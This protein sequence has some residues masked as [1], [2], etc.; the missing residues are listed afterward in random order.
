MKQQQNLFYNQ[1]IG[2][3]ELKTVLQSAFTNFGLNTAAFLSNQLKTVGF[4]YATKAG[5]SISI[6]DLKVPPLKKLLVSKTNKQITQTEIKAKRGEITDVERFQ[7]VVNTWS[8]TSEYLKD[9]VVSYF[10]E[11][12]P[13]NSVYMMAFSGAR[14][15]LSQVRQLVGMRGLMS[16]SKGQII[17]LPIKTNFREG[18][19][20]TDYII[21]SYGA[22][23]GLVDTALKTADS[24]YLT[25]R[26]IDVA[27][28][29]ITREYD[30]GTQTG[31]TITTGL[32]QK[33]LP[34]SFLE[35]FIG[36]VLVHEIINPFTNEIIANQY[37]ILDSELLDKIVKA[38][39]KKIIIRSPLS[40]ELNHS[41]CQLCYGWNL[42]SGNIVDLGEAIGII[43]AQSIGEP[44][45]QLTMR[46]F[47]TGGV[48]T[49]EASRQFRSEYSG[50]ILLPENCIYQTLRTEYGQLV[51]IPDKD[52]TVTL[53]TYSNKV[54]KLDILAK[55]KIFVQ[56]NEY[57]KKDD[58]LFEFP[59]L[60][61]KSGGEKI[62]KPVFAKN[63]GE[64]FLKAT[65]KNQNNFTNSN[66]I[67][68]WVL[69]A[70]IYK[71]PL[72]AK[73]KFKSLCWIDSNTTLA[74][75]ILTNTQAGRLETSQIQNQEIETM[76]VVHNSYAFEQ[77][78]IYCEAI[79]SQF[80]GFSTY[81]NQYS[82]L[83]I[84][85][86]F[87]LNFNQK[88]RTS[89][90]TIRNQ[91]L[92]TQTGGIF[93]C[94][95]SLENSTT[96]SELLE[97]RVI[98]TGTTLF[99]IPESNHS[100]R[101]KLSDLNLSE[102]GYLNAFINNKD[103]NEVI[104]VSGFVETQNKKTTKKELIIKPACFIVLTSKETAAYYNQQIFYPGEIIE[105]EFTV[106]RLC[107]GE[108]KTIKGGFLLL[109]R[110]ITRYEIFKKEN[111]SFNQFF[112]SSFPTSD[113]EVK[114]SNIINS[115]FKRVKTSVPIQIEEN[116]II[117]KPANSIKPDI[118]L[119]KSKSNTFKL[120]INL[121]ET[122]KVNSLIPK[123]LK[124]ED[125]FLSTLTEMGQFIEPYSIV[126]TCEILTTKKNYIY[127]IKEQFFDKQKR[128]LLVTEEDYISFF[129]ENNKFPLSK[130]LFIYNKDIIGNNLTVQES[131]LIREINGSKILMQKGKPY[132]FSAGT[133]LKKNNTF[134]INKNDILGSLIYER[135]RTGDIVQGLPRVEEILEARNPK[136]E[137]TL[138]EQSG[139]IKKIEN[140][141]SRI[142][143][144]VKGVG[145]KNTAQ[146]ELD[147]YSILNRERLLINKFEFVNVGQCLND[148]QI[149][150]HGLLKICFN[151]YSTLQ[152][153]SDYR[154]AQK[155]FKR[156][157][158]L[159]LNS[160]QGVYYSQGV[161]ISDKHIEI[162]IKQM[163]K[164]VQISYA[165]GLDLLPEEII[166]LKQIYF[167]NK[168]IHSEDKAKFLPIL[169]GIT[170]ASLKTESFIA[171]ASFQ[172]TT[173]IL[174][175]AAIQGKVDWLRGL[176]ENVIVG[177]LIPAGTGFGAYIDI[178]YLK[179][180]IP[181]L[182]TDYRP[183]KPNTK[184]VSLRQKLDLKKK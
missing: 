177:R 80:N 143:I 27:Q 92:K 16:D 152:L 71:V 157:Q 166:D 140:E 42:A 22:R 19:T 120:S 68:A 73:L 50:Q 113:I 65:D 158:F 21:S 124:K 165:G 106:K 11:T 181:T 91:Q 109:F 24:G 9:R 111:E 43:A 137:A 86:S 51:L 148:A 57:I 167:M 66:N 184:Y 30:C 121:S 62:I 10:K 115:T 107:Y 183:R 77:L 136:T 176:K 163:T 8:G 75:T 7:K 150:P 45:T 168:C 1:I 2:K 127:K 40:C 38:D 85:Y 15:N 130:D 56:N 144:W 180:R 74:Q 36:R 35:R 49:A 108:V 17:Y 5:I 105:N 69:N 117:F 104:P 154:A 129:I 34:I 164:K 84:N 132:L 182:S 76:R 29:V 97:K 110:P 6:E 78:K 99:Y 112:N 138:V 81:L 72:Q 149:N 26:L 161:N 128:I 41:V 169:L 123:E 55:T 153:F 155:S 95:S 83:Y 175:E 118:R 151:S 60:R 89:F 48:F 58:I 70:Q 178:S 79:E 160:I 103:K 119:T 146:T 134:F 61:K 147:R 52:I 20:V 142:Q 33:Q 64:V 54:L 173:T 90:G 87:F 96:Q 32:T 37:E 13:L 4:Q 98:E 116:E 23:K 39:I 18:L 12:D 133:S 162:I 141:N 93:L 31:I 59:S 145:K 179:V 46:T 44:G 135:S 14:G 174:T 102:F 171:A 25:R 131:G 63:S 28:D 3:K 47:H 139:I 156:I 122:I 170:K 88:Q 159:L 67:V 53:T 172:Q 126:S 114:S 82:T 125:V 101:V 94:V 100:T